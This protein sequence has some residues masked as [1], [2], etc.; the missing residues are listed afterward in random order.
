MSA[1]LVPGG[2]TFPTSL[3]DGKLTIHTG[4]KDIVIPLDWFPEPV[5]VSNVN[6]SSDKISVYLVSD[7]YIL[8]VRFNGTASVYTKDK[9]LVE[10]REFSLPAIAD[11]FIVYQKGSAVDG[12]E[13]NLVSVLADKDSDGVIICSPVHDGYYTLYL[14]D[15]PQYF[16]DLSQPENYLPIVVIEADKGDKGVYVYDHLHKRPKYALNGEWHI[17][18]SKIKLV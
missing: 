9:I 18:D 15:N 10:S 1:K 11:N 2:Q 8:I 12:N 3:Q 7:N 17:Y 16:D 14:T 6:Y 5:P 4:I 13:L